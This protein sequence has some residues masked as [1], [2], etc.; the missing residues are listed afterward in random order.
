MSRVEAVVR[1][2]GTARGDVDLDSDRLLVLQAQHGDESAFTELYLRYNRRI[3]RIAMR[4]LRD[5]HEAEDVAQEAFAR[6]WRGLPTFAGDRHFYPWVAVIAANLCTDTLRRRDRST[7]VAEIVACS[8]NGEDGIGDDPVDAAQTAT[9]VQAFDRL[10]HRH[11]H[12]LRLREESGWSYRAIAEHEG[13]GL[14]AVE[15]LLWRA[16]QALKREY[17]ALAGSHERVGVLTGAGVLSLA[18][19][20]RLLR[21]PS[22]MLHHAA[23]AVRR[24]T[25]GL[26]P[27][28]G[29]AMVAL[30][31]ALPAVPLL[32]GAAPRT[33]EGSQVAL[34]SSGPGVEPPA[35]AQRAPGSDDGGVPTGSPPPARDAGPASVD[36]PSPPTTPPPA[37][38]DGAGGGAVEGLSSSVVSGVGALA[39]DATRSAL[40]GVSGVLSAGQTTAS[41]L[42]GSLGSATAGVDDAVSG[43]PAV[44][45]GTTGGLAAPLGDAVSALGTVVPIPSQLLSRGLG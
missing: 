24:L 3:F 5:T 20:R 18:T 10:S 36:P 22:R 41:D 45:G 2:T 25:A 11:Q 33:G 1:S 29:V 14:A 34:E 38:G 8:A 15:A 17:L 26:G 44:G 13:L 28:A 40:Q 6:A 30:A 16:R 42:I 21:S 37:S 35:T 19:L 31:A 9:V 4:R 27:V 39:G 32:G 23:A 7:P 43:A 12:I